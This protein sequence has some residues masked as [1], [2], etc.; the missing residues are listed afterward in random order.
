MEDYEFINSIVDEIISRIE[1]NATEL[2][3]IVEVLEKDEDPALIEKFPTVFVIPMGDGEMALQNIQGEDGNYMDF[4]VHIVGIYKTYGLDAI[5]D[6]L[7]PTRNYGLVC[8]SL[9]SGDNGV[10]TENS[11]R[12]NST[13]RTGYWTAVDYVLHYFYLTIQIKSINC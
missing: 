13:M 2:G 11:I 9:F 5:E 10:I 12:I 3:G 4:P 7:R 8:N 1:N 6:G